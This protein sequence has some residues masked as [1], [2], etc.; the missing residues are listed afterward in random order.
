[1]NSNQEFKIQ[2]FGEITI[3]A[4]HEQLGHVGSNYVS[5]LQKYIR[6]SMWVL[7]MNAA[8]S[9]RCDKAEY[10]IPKQKSFMYAR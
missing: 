8:Q 10:P 2:H 6:W 4:E 9:L 3:Q 1:M 7:D 5:L